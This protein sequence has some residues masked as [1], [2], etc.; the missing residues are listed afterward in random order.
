MHAWCA[1]PWI[2]HC[3]GIRGQ[4]RHWIKKFLEGCTQWFIVEG[5]SSC[6]ANVTSG[7]PQCSVLGLILFLIF[8]NDIMQCQHQF[9]TLSLCRRLSH[10]WY[11]QI[12]WRLSDAP[13]RPGPAN[14][15]GRHL[16]DDLQCQE[17]LYDACDLIKKET[18][19][20]YILHGQAENY[21]MLTRTHTWES[22]CI[23][24]CWILVKP[25]KVSQQGWLLCVH[26]HAQLVGIQCVAV[27]RGGW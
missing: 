19:T 5:Q 13:T 6:M 1:S 23:C 8:I 12:S 16:A 20:A 3:Y 11:H 24:I 2:H 15:M 10:I 4:T 21:P 17:M 25:T 27:P 7:V 9:P 14:I 22:I 18:I 26:V